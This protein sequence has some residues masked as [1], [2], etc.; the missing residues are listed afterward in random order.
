[1]D[2]LL[3]LE[4]V[5]VSFG[6]LIVFFA[7]FFESVILLGFLL[8]GG[9]IV[10]LGGY[11]AQQNQMSVIW[12]IILAWSGMFLGDLLNYWLVKY[13]FCGHTHQ[14]KKTLVNG[15]TAI[16]IGSDYLRKCFETIEI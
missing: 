5:F 16:N 1:M 9:L 12:V 11:F 6:Y 2:I 8:P 3:I 10:L 7:A 4:S 13:V 14:K 15:I